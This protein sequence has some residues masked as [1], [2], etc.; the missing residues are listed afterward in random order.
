MKLKKR[1]FSLLL[2][3]LM[4]CA[5]QA[6]CMGK[7]AFVSLPPVED[8]SWAER[9]VDEDEL[10]IW[11]ERHPEL[12][13]TACVEILA[14]LNLKDH[15]YIREDM[16]KKRALKVPN[17]FPS[18]KNWSPLPTV[19]PQVAKAKKFVLVAKDTPFLGWYEN[20]SLVRDSYA[21]IGKKKNWTKAG[22]YKILDKDQDHVSQSYRSA[23]GYPALMPYAL[24]IYGHVWIHG[25]DVVGG[26][27]SR[28]CINLPLQ[29]AEE[30][31]SW[32]DKG[33]MV[34]VVESLKNLD[35]TLAKHSKQLVLSSL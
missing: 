25:G 4:A 15:A 9:T 3:L 13:L 16:K 21:C 6:G 8:L 34:L 10:L 35:Q 18:Y 5:F 26:N 33:T 12:N 17:D 30:L 23:Y 27:C 32:A 19:I 31:F 29:T 14:R 2:A 28:G 24:K 20:G 1:N 22:L 7:R 11:A